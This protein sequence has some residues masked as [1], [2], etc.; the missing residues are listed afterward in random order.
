MIKYTKKKNIAIASAA[1]F[2]QNQRYVTPLKI[3]KH[4]LPY[5]LADKIY[6]KMH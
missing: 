5:S 1:I 2:A 4:L 6:N 3:F